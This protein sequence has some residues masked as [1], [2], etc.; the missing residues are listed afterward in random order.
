MKVVASLV[1]PAYVTRLTAFTSHIRDASC[2]QSTATGSGRTGSLPLIM[3]DLEDAAFNSP[4]DSYPQHPRPEDRGKHRNDS[5]QEEEEDDD[6]EEDDDEEQEDDEDDDESP[7]KRK[8]A[9]SAIAAS[10]VH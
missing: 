8:K 6:R 1:E 3:S 7:R 2:C 9:R 5:E 10:T 4:Q